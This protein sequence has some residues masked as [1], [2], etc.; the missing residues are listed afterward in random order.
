VSHRPATAILG[1]LTAALSV[2]TAIRLVGDHGTRRLVVLDVVVPLLVPLLLVMVVV[3]LL[4]RRRKL[5]VVTAAVV[6]LN[7]LWLAPLYRAADLRQGASLTVMNANLLYGRADPTAVVAMV[8]DREVDVLATEELT[9]EEVQRLADAGV[10]RLLPFHVLA[11]LPGAEGCGLWSR[12]PLTALPAFALRYQAPGGVVVL[13]NGSKVVVRVVHPMAP[14]VDGLYQQDNVALRR[15][16]KA[17][18]RAVPTIVA[19]DF[20]GSQDNSLFRQLLS[21]GQL[22]DA[23][24]LAGSGLQ[25]TWSPVGW[26]G[27]LHLDHVLVNHLI[28]AR[29][30][31][32]ERLPGSDHRAV[33]ARLVIS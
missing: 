18:D 33:L 17:L 1:L 23:A 22:R 10:D 27:L 14:V 28:D 29:T 11:P 26:P 15:Q 5:A 9:P 24:E 6:A 3:Q 25:R 20:N 19:G 4:V 30:T 2:P 21:S 7:T 13:P 8:R 16:V 12:Y 31:S 32:V